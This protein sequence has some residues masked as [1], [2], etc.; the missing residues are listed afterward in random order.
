MLERPL[1]KL[2]SLLGTAAAGHSVP[3]QRKRPVSGQ[4]HR[5]QM[6][7]YICDSLFAIKTWLETAYTL[8]RCPQQRLKHCRHPL[9]PAWRTAQSSVIVCRSRP[10]Q[11]HS[12]PSPCSASSASFR[13]SITSTT[14]RSMYACS[15]RRQ[16]GAQ[17]VS[18]H[19]PPSIGQSLP[20]PPAASSTASARTLTSSGV[21]SLVCSSPSRRQIGPNRLSVKAT[22][23]W[24]QRGRSA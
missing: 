20:E 11:P 16:G 8:S 7:A 5:R 15:R 19:C 2:H 18:H 1:T 22:S 14:S 6:A 10:A 9:A 23:A 13:F 4:L 21:G 17:P 24:P 12:A 3:Q